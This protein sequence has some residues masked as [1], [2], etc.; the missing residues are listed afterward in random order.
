M[1]TQIGLPGDRAASAVI[2]ELRGVQEH[3]QIHLLLP[4]EKHAWNE[5][6][7]QLRKPKNVKLGNVVRPI[8]VLPVER[9]FRLPVTFYPF[10]SIQ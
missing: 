2:K 6:W 7:D 4:V 9:D 3:V 8:F 1:V 5:R 10:A